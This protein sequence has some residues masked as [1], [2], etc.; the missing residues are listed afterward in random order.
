MIHEVIKTDFSEQL[1]CTPKTGDYIVLY[2]EN[3]I[4]ALFIKG[5]MNRF[6]PC[7]NCYFNTKEFIGK[8]SFSC[9]GVMSCSGGTLI[10][11][12]IDVNDIPNYTPKKCPSVPVG[13]NIE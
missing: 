7:R 6:S 2:T 3:N 10:A 8:F 9:G 1:S 11:R 12:K 4:I 13:Y 5:A